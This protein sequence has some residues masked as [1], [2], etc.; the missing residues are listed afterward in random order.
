MPSEFWNIRIIL[1]IV[2]REQSLK[3]ILYN[4]EQDVLEKWI[5]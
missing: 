4:P 1:N 2:I 5:N 3:L